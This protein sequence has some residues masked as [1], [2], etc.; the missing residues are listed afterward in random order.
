MQRSRTRFLRVLGS[1][2][3]APEPPPSRDRLRRG[4]AG[5]RAATRAGAAEP[6]TGARAERGRGAAVE[7]RPAAAPRRHATARAFARPC[8][9]AE[10]SGAAPRMAENAAGRG[11]RRQ[12]VRQGGDLGDRR[13]RRHRKANLRAR[14]ENIAECRVQREDRDVGRR[15]VAARPRVPLADHAVDCRSAQRGARGGP[16]CWLAGPPGG[17]PLPASGEAAGDLYVRGSGDPTLATEDLAAMVG[18]LAALGLHKVRG[19]LVVDDSLFEGGNV[20]PAYEQKNDSTASRAPASAASLNGNV[21]AV[22]I[23]PGAAAGAPAHVVVDPPS[24]YFTIAGRVVTAS[25]GPQTPAVDTKE[26]PA[27][28]RVNVAGRIRLGGDP[29]TVYRR[30]AQPALFLGYTLKQQLERRGIS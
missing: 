17:P 10:G 15:A 2:G 27:H 3:V 5:D 13:R 9:A 16:R 21:V 4:P 24:P 20:P 26:E 1:P 14:R 30:V 25:G 28:T 11:V 6:T 22:T 29:R 12:G 19:A 18:D 8:Q 7:D 23:V